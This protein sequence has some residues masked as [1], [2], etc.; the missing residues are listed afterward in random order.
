[1]RS[2]RSRAAE[3]AGGPWLEPGEVGPSL[4]LP[5]PPSLDAAFLPALEAA[6]EGGGVAALL[7]DPAAAPASAFEALVAACRERC[8]KAGCALFLLHDAARVI[9][10]AADGLLA[11]GPEMVEPARRLLGLERPIGVA[12]GGSRHRAME[13][14]EAGADWLLLGD[15]TSPSTARELVAWWS[16]LFVL[17][18]AAP[19]PSAEAAA[20]LVAAG[21]DFL[22][23]EPSLWR[24][25]ATTLA[26][27]RTAL[28]TA[29]P[30][31]P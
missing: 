8:R 6:L 5:P 29:S 3:P 7:L 22:L 9:S 31:T 26:W 19:C 20:A 12:C 18:C 30:R 23:P 14:G 13:A 27:L 28:A 24:E 15:G 1:M 4:L 17:P 10:T 25:P 11:D 16:E 2:G 21:V